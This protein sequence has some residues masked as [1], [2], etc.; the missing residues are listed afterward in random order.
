MTCTVGNRA[1]GGLGDNGEFILS[2]DPSC[3]FLTTFALRV[4]L[5]YAR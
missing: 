2:S 4:L 1:W 5:L 3:R